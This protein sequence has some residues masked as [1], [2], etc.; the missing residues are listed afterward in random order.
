M[1][2]CLAG[3]MTIMTSSYHS[4]RNL[5]TTTTPGQPKT[6]KLVDA[7]PQSQS[8]GHERKYL[9]LSL[10][11]DCFEMQEECIFSLDLDAD[12]EQQQS[13]AIRC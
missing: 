8:G 10:C 7:A 9:Y 11:V 1:Q 6:L 13:D 2:R 3:Q 4:L 12:L 5:S